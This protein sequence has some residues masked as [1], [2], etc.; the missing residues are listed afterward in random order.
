MKFLPKLLITFL[1]LSLIPLGVFALFIY[2]N[3]SQAI[4]REETQ[5]LRE[6]SGEKVVELRNYFE[7]K[8][9]EAVLIA[10]SQVLL[11]LV[12][13]KAQSKDE[14]VNQF[15]YHLEQIYNVEGITVIN[16]QGVVIY[17]AK[18]RE[19][20]G[21]LVG[22]SKNPELPLAFQRSS[23]LLTPNTSHLEQSPESGKMV[24][25]VSSPIFSE[26]KIVGV[27][28]FQAPP[29]KLYR[30]FLD[31]TGLR[32]TGEFLVGQRRGSY[33]D[34]V[35]PTRH[36]PQDFFSIEMGS[37]LALPMQNAVQGK[38]GLGTSIDYRGVKIIAVWDYF[39]YLDLGMVVKRDYAEATA[40][41]Q[42]LRILIITIGLATVL[43]TMGVAFWLSRA[44]TSPIR[45]LSATME[46]VSKGNL[47]MAV[48]MDRKDEF[49]SLSHSLS[50]MLEELRASA[51]SVA[52]LNAEVKRR[53]AAEDQLRTFLDI[54]VHE[55]RG[56]ITPIQEGVSGAL[57]YSQD[58]EQKKL[59][60]IALANSKRLYV[61]AQD[62]L[63]LRSLE[64]QALRFN[65][66]GCNLNAIVKDS[67]EMLI[68]QAAEKGLFLDQHLDPNI[69]EVFADRDRLIQVMVNLISNA[70][71]Y[72]EKG[73]VTIRTSVLE[74]CTKVQV[75]NTG[76]GISKED[77]EKLFRRFVRLEQHK[78]K[79]IPGTGLGLMIA[80]MIVEAHGGEIA[81]ESDETTGTTF[82]FTLPIKK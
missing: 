76:K 48:K 24:V 71:K 10:H 70:L 34:F 44:F 28:A 55:L 21:L 68:R 57:D 22:K 47:E 62:L 20:E 14:K 17:C 61:I 9:K 79:R 27:V 29:D 54:I 75:H 23:L 74:H 77:Q 63:Q 69:P 59:L 58:E 33:I 80:R 8:E 60:N 36:A 53:E 42:E 32:E 73:K 45:Q 82:S 7:T 51:T 49:G 35:I 31:Y 12:E 1:C 3:H 65:M 50:D 39:P 41:V 81:V 67:C 6:L 30:F 26:Q 37:G 64:Q 4:L 5:D 11:E 15:F 78:E 38:R 19:I 25:T 18:E 2:Q 46:E 66:V 56:P 16:Q 40:S 72:G 13:G 52:A 43:I